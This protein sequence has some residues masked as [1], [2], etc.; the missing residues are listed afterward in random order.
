MKHML[1][2][3]FILL[4]I[5]AGWQYG[6]VPY[7]VKKE[8]T[9]DLFVEE[10]AVKESVAARV[11]RAHFPVILPVRAPEGYFQNES[12]LGLERYAIGA[13]S[14]HFRYANPQGT[15]VDVVE[16]PL[17]DKESLEPQQKDGYEVK[18]VDLAHNTV[19]YI[20]RGVTPIPPVYFD[21]QTFVPLPETSK[22]IF[23]AKET[24][25]DIASKNFAL[26]GAILSEY[27]LISFAES[28]LK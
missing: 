20:V 14:F 13:D 15:I 9:K 16:R 10:K 7:S 26:Y 18:K 1:G 25:I 21:R 2:T 27:D 12:S 28:F 3:I 6:Y 4:G 8:M 17:K 23:S 19:G 24:R 11:S 22:I 5:I